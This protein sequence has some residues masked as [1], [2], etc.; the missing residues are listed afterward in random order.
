MLNI[1]SNVLENTKKFGQITSSLKKGG[2]EK[3][4]NS[5]YKNY[6]EYGERVI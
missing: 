4:E 2:E 5:T 3:D 1:E 6:Y